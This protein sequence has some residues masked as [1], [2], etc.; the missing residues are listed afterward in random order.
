MSRKV[1]GT[2]SADGPDHQQSVDVG[3]D[4]GEGA[5]QKSVGRV[6]GAAGRIGQRRDA[7]TGVDDGQVDL[8]PDRGR[9][10]FAVVRGRFRPGRSCLRERRPRLRSR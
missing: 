5:D 7:R 9:A 8:V 1:C 6:D 10:A 2:V 3:I 4:D